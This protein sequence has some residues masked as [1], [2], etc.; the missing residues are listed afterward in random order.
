MLWKRRYAVYKQHNVEDCGAAC[1]AA[2]VKHFG[3]TTTLAKAREAVGTSQQGTTL[4]GLQRGAETIGFFSRA[5]QADPA[6]LQQLHEMPL[7]AILHWRGVHWVVFYGQQGKR[8]VI[9]DPAVGLR[10]LNRY[11]FREG[12][13]D[14]VALLLTP[15]P[16]RLAQQNAEQTSKLFQFF[17][18][19]W[20]YR[21]ILGQVFLINLVLGTLS[22]ATPFLIQILTD[23]V[24]VRQDANLLNAVAI[25]I[26]TLLVFSNL[27]SWIQSNLILHFSKRLE[28]NMLMDFCR[29]LLHLPLQ[30]FE[31]HRSG[32][33]VSRL[34]DVYMVY[35]MVSQ[36]VVSLPGQIFVAFISLLLMLVYS[37]PLTLAAL[38]IGALM[39][40]STIAFLPALQ[41]RT[42]EALVMDA[43]NQ[44]VLVETFKGAITFKSLVATHQLWEELQDR[45]GRLATLTFHTSQIGI[46]NSS[47]AGVVS[48][49]GNIGLLWIGSRIVMQGQLSIGQLL[50]F[51][52]MNRNFMALINTLIGVMD[53]MARVR[54]ATQRLT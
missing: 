54:A 28:L 12:W 35:Q 48:G 6:V 19:A 40:L 33:V 15:D 13:S 23:D 22:L 14:W 9:M 17:Q 11:E 42:R 50:A 43:D 2:I 1:I 5:V 25:A 27:L 30:Y 4:L 46:A 10:Y 49:L 36:I 39:S 29:K 52:A 34:Q 24:L 3:Y 41:R 44:G 8:F 16:P 21:I 20:F 38:I 47:F 18:Q 37:P 32:E 7:P 51:H 45:L 31:D 26:A 53:E